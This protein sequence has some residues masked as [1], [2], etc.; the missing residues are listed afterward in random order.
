[1]KI[2]VL[3]RYGFIGATS[4]LRFYQYFEHLK[5]NGIEYQVEPLFSDDYV[6][7]LY[8][9]IPPIF[10]IIKSYFRR[11]LIT[12]RSEKYDLIWIEKEMLPWLP[13]WL[14]FSLLRRNVPFVIDYDD[15][16]FHRYDQFP[17]KAIRAIYKNKI[18]KLMK[19]ADIVI[20]GN[21]Y[22]ADYAYGYKCKRVVII[23]TVVDTDKYLISSKLSLS[24]KIIVGWIGSPST[25]R[26]LIEI[27]DIIREL[28]KNPRIQFMAIG[29]HPHQLL[30]LPIEILPWSIET[31]ISI[32]QK[33]DI[34]IMPLPDEP[35][36][37]GKC[38][39]KLIQYMACGKPVVASPVGVNNLIVNAVNNN[40]FLASSKKDW[41]KSL[42]LLINDFE[43]RKVMGANGRKI[44]EK[45]F[46]IKIALE[47]LIPAFNSVTQK[48]N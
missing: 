19:K 34:G 2:L 15:A 9:K 42:N 3:T 4:R 14:E 18:A 20:A 1:M 24:D 35:F 22:I 31:E 21:Q 41:I 46:S 33:F 44:V 39:F 47:K 28:A 5:L 26:Y 32:I 6:K 36:E 12:Q 10:S 11:I 27:E 45:H 7:S 38:G 17:V 30:N 16:T 25:A 40:G 8:I 23:P 29:A 37:R 13:S 48:T 43:L